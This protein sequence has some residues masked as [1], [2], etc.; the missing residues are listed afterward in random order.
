MIRFTLRDKSPTEDQIYSI[1][2][3]PFIGLDTV[4]GVP[5]FDV[6]EGTVGAHDLDA[7][8]NHTT[9]FWLNGGIRGEV[10]KLLIHQPTTAGQD[11]DAEIIIGVR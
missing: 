5:T 1:D 11:L 8:D 2:W 10:A 6:L 3:T 7:P 4:A 9:R